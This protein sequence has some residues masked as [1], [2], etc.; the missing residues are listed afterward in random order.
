MPSLPS[1]DLLYYTGMESDDPKWYAGRL[2]AFTKATRLKMSPEGMNGFLDM[3]VKAIE[4]ELKYM[5]KTIPS[6]WE[7]VD[8]I[9]LFSNVSR[10]TA[11]QITRSRN[12]SFAM[13]SQ[14]VT[15]VSS[16]GYYTPECI[17][18]D[19]SLDALYDTA[20]MNAKDAYSQLVKKGAALED[21]REVLPVAT[22]CN[23]VAKYNFRNWIE[24]VRKRHS[25]RVQGPYRE[26]VAQMVACVTE[27]WPWAHYFLA[28]PQ[29]TAI[30]MIE[31]VA[32]DLKKEDGAMYRGA[33]GELAKAADLLKS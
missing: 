6:S 25:L 13:Q 19:P 24:L 29:D 11:Q 10:S 4:E 18:A 8:L 23:I 17:S 27:A 31:K 16:A 30:Q 20:I 15:D 9:F 32:L 26:I 21:A 28:N 2:L 3:D 1:V 33:S 14:R 7:F 12:A 22:H 5:A